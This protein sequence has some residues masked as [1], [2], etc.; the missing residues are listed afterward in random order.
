MR[1]CVR[2]APFLHRI[3]RVTQAYP[4]R[5][6]SPQ[7]AGARGEGSTR[8]EGR[9]AGAAWRQRER[10]NRR[11]IRARAAA[12]TTSVL[13]T[14]LRDFRSVDSWHHPPL[15]KLFWRRSLVAAGVARRAQRG[16]VRAPACRCRVS[17][18]VY[19]REVPLKQRENLACI[20]TAPVSTACW[21]ATGG[22]SEPS[23]EGW[24]GALRRLARW[25]AGGCRPHRVQHGPPRRLHDVGEAAHFC[26]RRRGADGTQTFYGRA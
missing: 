25:L 4:R 24:H 19:L 9:V 7:A 14:S 21:Q 10:G 6:Q 11:R 17:H 22:L 23:P 18:V 15:A 5:H 20:G 3:A 8:A 2:W 16:V 1:Q 13:Q 26:G 12:P